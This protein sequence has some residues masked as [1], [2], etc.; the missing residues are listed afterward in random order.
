VLATLQELQAGIAVAAAV[1]ST[2]S[3]TVT[4]TGKVTVNTT[5]GWFVIG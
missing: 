1:P 4:L 5:V 3:F 2:G